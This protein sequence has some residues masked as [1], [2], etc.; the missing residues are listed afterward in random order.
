MRFGVKVTFLIGLVSV[1]CIDLS[2]WKPI[3]GSNPSLKT[4]NQPIVVDTS[5]LSSASSSKSTI[6]FNGQT[7]TTSI[8]G[9]GNTND[10]IGSVLTV[11]SSDLTSGIDTEG[12][13]LDY[14]GKVLS[15]FFSASA[16]VSH[17]FYKFFF[18]LPSDT[19]ASASNQLSGRKLIYNEE[20]KKSQK[21]KRAVNAQTQRKNS[22]IWQWK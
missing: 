17:Q 1:H 12:R 14:P 16:A 21:K 13:Y 11:D 19:F 20:K 6:T 18:F 3:I 2:D 8:G 10:G 7:I 22:I 15:G 4:L 5:A 9:D